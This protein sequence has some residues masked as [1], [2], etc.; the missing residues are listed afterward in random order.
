[1]LKGDIEMCALSTQLANHAIMIADKVG[2]VF[3]G[4]NELWRRVLGVM[5]VKWSWYHEVVSPDN[6]CTGGAPVI[7][8]LAD[9]QTEV[10]YQDFG[11]EDKDLPLENPFGGDVGLGNIAGCLNRACFDEYMGLR[12]ADVKGPQKWRLDGPQLKEAEQGGDLPP[13]IY[14]NVSFYPLVKMDDDFFVRFRSMN[15]K[16]VTYM[17]PAIL[18][19]GYA[20]IKPATAIK[21]KL[22]IKNI[23]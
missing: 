17:A 11:A 15:V 1:M 5:P 2:V 16:D 18:K 6:P 7:S 23:T 10:V 21:R 4:S 19:T 8:G 12:V 13:I 9:G 22:P 14:G 20:T 3:P